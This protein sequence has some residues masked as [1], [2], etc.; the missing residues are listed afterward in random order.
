ML[1]Q[2]DGKIGEHQKLRL[3]NVEAKADRIVSEELGRLNWKETDLR[4]GRKSD[5]AKLAMAARLCLETTLPIK[6]IA[7]RLTIATYPR[8]LTK[9]DFLVHACQKPAIIARLFLMGGTCSILLAAKVSLSGHGAR[10]RPSPSA[11]T[12]SASRPANV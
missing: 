10:P 12:P 6:T 1:E 2:I 7:S 3:E 11:A 8:S 5:S 9:A 4:S